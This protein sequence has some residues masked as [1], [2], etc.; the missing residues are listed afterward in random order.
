MTKK[1]KLEKIFAIR[2]EDIPNELYDACMEIDDEFPLHY[3]CGIVRVVDNE[4][5]FAKW[6]KKQG[7]VFDRKPWDEKEGWWG[8]LGV[9]GT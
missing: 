9:W 7:F 1:V 2:A 3:S 5:S 6:I 8:W 4:N